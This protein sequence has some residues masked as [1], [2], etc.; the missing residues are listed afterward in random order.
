M[1]AQKAIPWLSMHCKGK[2]WSDWSEMI[3]GRYD[4]HMKGH[5]RLNEDVSTLLT[6]ELVKYT[7]LKFLYLTN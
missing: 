2:S 7:V 5:H 6:K 4:G 1:Q 3:R